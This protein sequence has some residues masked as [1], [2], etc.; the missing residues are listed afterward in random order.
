[1]P[2]RPHAAI[3]QHQEPRE[4]DRDAGVVLDDF[5]KLGR[6]Y[7]ETDESHADEE[8]IIETLL[9]GQYSNPT[10]VVSFN[11]S[12][13]WSRDVSEDIAGAGQA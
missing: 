3:A 12:E 13:G 11:I 2:A 7:R 9:H 10:R 6:A 5:G 8:T 1:M 4:P